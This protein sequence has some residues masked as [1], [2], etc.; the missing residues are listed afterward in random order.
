MA[1]KVGFVGP[2]VRANLAGDKLL[3]NGGTV[4]YAYAEIETGPRPLLNLEIN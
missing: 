4:K 3:D 1:V 2:D